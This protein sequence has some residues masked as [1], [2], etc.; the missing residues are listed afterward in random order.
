MSYLRIRRLVEAARKI[1]DPRDP[2]GIRARELL[3]ES[4]GLSRQGVEWA[5]TRCLETRPTEKELRQ[6][7]ASV[8]TAPRA[9][10][11][12]SANVFVAAHRA[13]ALALAASPRVCVRTS[14]REPQFARLLCQASDGLFEI[15]DNE[16]ASGLRC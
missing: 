7:S 3:P 16:E 2:L 10:V 6:L 8:P 4:T 13:I 1:A 14:R 9:H 15:S 12:L 5:L 11:I